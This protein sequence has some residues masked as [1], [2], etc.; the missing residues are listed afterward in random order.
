M[1]FN[2][3][4]S[5]RLLEFLNEELGA[6]RY[7]EPP[8]S[9][10][11]GNETEVYAL[12]LEGLD[13]P[14]DGPLVLRLFR[15]GIEPDKAR[16]EAAVQNAV[17]DQGFPAARA[18]AICE[19]D[20]VLGAPFF[21]MDRLPGKPLFGETLMLSSDGVPGVQRGG[22]M[23]NGLRMLVEI[24]RTLAEVD[25]R[26]HALD[27]SLV[28]A[29]LEQ[30]GLAWQRHTVEGQLREMSE[31]CE[32]CW[33]DGLRACE[34]LKAQLPPAGDR[35]VL[36]HGDMQPLNLLVQGGDVSGVVDW[37]NAFFG[38][39]ECEIGWTRSTFLTLPLPLPRPVRPAER[40]IAAAIANGYSR[41]YR[42]SR[43]LDE[44]AVR[45]YEAF[46]DVIILCNLAERMHRGEVIR[47]AWNSAE[48]QAKVVAHFHSITGQTIAAPLGAR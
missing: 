40:L 16:T 13:P 10:V 20:D 11:R 18:H 43:P 27:A 34:W 2:A 15:P 8:T 31:R 42:R 25:V 46:H 21:V 39:P 24:P 29:A 23:R 7:A 14:L 36:C 4:L 35:L 33:A 41:A 5:A 32:R 17:A 30:A 28:I 9:M 44:D 3:A 19:R 47:D 22:F 1:T 45:Y 38:A 48:A 37:S 6:C 26:I 12:R